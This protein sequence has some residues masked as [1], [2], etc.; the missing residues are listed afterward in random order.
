MPARNYILLLLVIAFSVWS[1]GFAG[2][3]FY[4][5]NARLNDTVKTSDAILVLTG[6]TDRVDVGLSLFASG[7][8]SHLFIS[9]VHP[10]TSKADIIGRWD[11][12]FALPPCC[13]EI[14]QTATSTVENAMEISKWAE[15]KAIHDAI[16]VTSNYHMP[17]AMQDIRAA[18]PGIDF[19]PYPIHQSDLSFTAPKL[20]QLLFSEYHKFLV[21]FFSLLVR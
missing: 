21:R 13:L 9:G 1:L 7:K 16:L 3:S 18:M 17:R 12:D 15:G 2:F 5:L 11:G 19:H 20:W 8:A 14:G 4:A 10:D 6:G